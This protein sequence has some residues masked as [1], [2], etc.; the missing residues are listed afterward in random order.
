MHYS[1]KMSSNF[2]QSNKMKTKIIKLM[3]N[4][5]RKDKQ[6]N[7]LS[8]DVGVMYIN[9]CK[10]EQTQFIYSANHGISFIRYLCRT[11]SK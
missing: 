8:K 6:V 7:K 2:A 5:V 3:M 11:Y 4:E 9:F 10:H 1:F